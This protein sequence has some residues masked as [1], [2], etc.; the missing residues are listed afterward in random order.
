MPIFLAMSED[1]FIKQAKNPK[2]HW[3]SDD[4]TDPVDNTLLKEPDVEEEVPGGE[5]E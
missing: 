4:L 1:G 2:F 5:T 3:L